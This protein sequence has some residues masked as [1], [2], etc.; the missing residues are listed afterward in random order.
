MLLTDRNW[1]AGVG[2]G[3][4]APV[5]TINLAGNFFRLTFKSKT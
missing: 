2:E 5:M 1:P 3:L 4:E